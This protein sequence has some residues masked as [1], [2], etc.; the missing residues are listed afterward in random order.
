M[1]LVRRKTLKER[2]LAPPLSPILCARR[3]RS[4][5]SWRPW[6]LLPVALRPRTTARWWCWKKSNRRSC[7]QPALILKAEG[8][9]HFSHFNHIAGGELALAHNIFTVDLQPGLALRGRDEIF[10]VALADESGRGR[11]EKTFQLDGCHAGLADH[12]HLACEHVFLL[13]GLP[14]Q[15]VQQAN[16]VFG[17]GGKGLSHP[18]GTRNPQRPA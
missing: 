2:N 3:S 13:I 4:G 16:A 10:V 14:F 5:K 17:R 15:N 11:S 9:F 1:A 6:N 18:C 12:G 7:F 8:R